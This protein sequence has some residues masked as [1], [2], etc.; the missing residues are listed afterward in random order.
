MDSFGNFIVFIT[1]V[2]EKVG[3][4]TDIVK[5]NIGYGKLS[6]DARYKKL[7]ESTQKISDSNEEKICYISTTSI[8]LIDP[9]KLKNI[10]G[11]ENTLISSIE[12]LKIYIVFSIQKK[13]RIINSC[14]LLQLT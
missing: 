7:V 13:I 9:Q 6:Q 2:T 14:L 4:Y 11:Q 8:T 3:L 10:G 5:K 1:S 12:F